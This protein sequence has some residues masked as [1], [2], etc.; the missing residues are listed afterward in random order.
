MPRGL[1]KVIGKAQRV[2]KENLDKASLEAELAHRH[3]DASPGA[4][5]M[6]YDNTTN[7]AKIDSPVN[8]IIAQLKNRRNDYIENLNRVNATILELEAKPGLAQ[9]LNRLLDKGVI[10]R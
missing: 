2:L 3:I 8:D 6:G 1:P 10:Y 7:S 5:T 4:A 9:E